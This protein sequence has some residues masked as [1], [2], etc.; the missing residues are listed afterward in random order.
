MEGNIKPL[1]SVIIPIYNIEQYLKQCV[2]SIVNQTYKNLEIILVDDGSADNSV[3]ICDEYALKDNRIKVIHKQNA[4]VSA[5]RNDGLNIAKGEYIAFVDGDDY[6]GLKTFEDV[7]ELLLN[8]DVD[9]VKYGAK[10]IYKRK[11]K[12]N[13]FGFEQKAYKENEKNNLLKCIIK[14]DGIDNFVS[15]C[16]F[17][18]S[19]IETYNIRFSEK[20]CQGDDLCFLIKYLL[21][22]NSI[23]LASNLFYYNY[24]QNYN[25]VTKRYSKRYVGD[26]IDLIYEM[27]TILKNHKNEDSYLNAIGFRINKFIFYILY[28]QA[29]FNFFEIREKIKESKRFLSKIPREIYLIAINNKPKGIKF[30]PVNLFHKGYFYLSL[31]FMYILKSGYLL[32]I[33]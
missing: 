30:F 11:E 17:K 3:R 29:D 14:N 4:G 2:D 32:F 28:L 6:I 13:I 8:F 16:L 10:T 25:S 24:V 31:F 15:T 22:S 20:L 19:I 27:L 33:K 21:C 5:A 12:N 23:F 7:L 1:I 18:K 26:I 9:I